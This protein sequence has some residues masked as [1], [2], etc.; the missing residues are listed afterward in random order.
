MRIIMCMASGSPTGGSK[1]KAATPGEGGKAK[2][3]ADIHTR[4]PEA[5]APAPRLEPVAVA[6]VA[7]AAVVVATLQ[8]TPAS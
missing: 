5:E 6:A 3:R 2:G 8:Q 4:M 1:P 7:V